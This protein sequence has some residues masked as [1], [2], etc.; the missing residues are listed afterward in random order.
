MI[1][2]TPRYDWQR[3]EISALYA[4]PFDTL[5]ARALAVKSANWADGRV[6]K[7]Q[8]LSIKTGGCAENC[9][10]CSQS[11]HFD[12]GL[13]AERLMEL[14]EVV[15]AARRAKANGADR[16]CMGAAWRSLKDR[17]LPKSPP[18]SVL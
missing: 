2:L 14:D 15:D 17:D 13:K 3:D 11:A 8:L 10:Y 5:I 1:K 6:Q 12:T 7:S 18:W 9:G 16:F 4:L